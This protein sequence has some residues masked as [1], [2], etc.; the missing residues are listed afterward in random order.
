[1]EYTTKEKT[2]KLYILTE[3][4]LQTGIMKAL[5]YLGKAFKLSDVIDCPLI[6]Y[7]FKDII[8]EQAEKS[9][10]IIERDID[11]LG[12]LRNCFPLKKEKSS[13]DETVV[14]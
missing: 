7:D 9:G 5:E 12:I 13:V 11:I 6:L 1:M 2:M 3:E 4:A 14:E 8:I 10:H